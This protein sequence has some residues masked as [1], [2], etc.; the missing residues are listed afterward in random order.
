MTRAYLVAARRTAIGRIGG[1]HKSR[2]LADLAAPVAR[3][4]LEDAKIEPARVEEMVIGNTSEG[5]NPARLVALSA[6][7]PETAG[8]FTI[9]RQCGSGLDAIVSAAHAVM[10]GH[11]NVAAAGGAE[12]LSTAPWR[13][14]RGRSPYTPPNFLP[15]G[16]AGETGDG[17]QD[18][19][20]G[21]DGLA[22]R[23]GLSRQ[24]QDQWARQSHAA[25]ASAREA[26][27]FVGE[28]LPL[29]HNAEELRDQSVIEADLEEFEEATAFSPPAGTATPGNTSALADGAGMAVIVSEAVWDSLGRPPA[30]ALVASAAVGVRPGEDASAPL[31]AMDKLVL[32]SG[33]KVQDIGAIELNEISAAQ[34]IA[35]SRHVACAG[36]VLN[37][38]GG[39]VA[40]GHPLAAAGAVLVA[41]LFTRMVRRPDPEP[42]RFGVAVLGT[43]GGM[44]V[45]AL[46][47][48]TGG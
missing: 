5:G 46:F 33:I 29:R 28:I 12:C 35:F 8:A 44:G 10:A 45:A 9:D 39:A 15:F 7:L 17:A 18:H 1:L 27:R 25:A 13:V 20:A 2:R 37:A 31:L 19:F 32:R 47:E 11:A 42:A 22:A 30:L 6:M 4:A 48:R 21:S 38:D 3:A 26:G 43:Y 24:D 36:R 41:R 40:R 14:A 34:A 23:L 16:P